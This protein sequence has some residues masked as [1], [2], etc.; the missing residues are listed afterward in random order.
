[1]R[2]WRVHVAMN[3]THPRTQASSW[4][5]ENSP[6]RVRVVLRLM[7]HLW[8]KTPCLCG[9]VYSVLIQMGLPHDNPLKIYAGRNVYGYFF[10]FCAVPSF[11]FPVEFLHFI[12]TFFFLNSSLLPSASAVRT[13]GALLALVSGWSR[14]RRYTVIVNMGNWQMSNYNLVRIRLISLEE[15]RLQ[16]KNDISS[17]P[18]I[19]CF[20][21]LSEQDLGSI[22]LV[23]AKISTFQISQA[24]K[25]SQ[26]YS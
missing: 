17:V 14:G 12:N 8:R 6:F 1:M 20:W 7:F 10:F 13:G 24:G 16:I 21:S 25:W 15:P 5:I 18:Q 2:G 11:A 3:N 4:S 22:V 26:N 19:N 23:W 9:G